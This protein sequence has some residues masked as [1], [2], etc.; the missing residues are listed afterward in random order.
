LPFRTPK[1]R[2]AVAPIQNS[3]D[4]TSFVLFRGIDPAGNTT[5]SA[6]RMSALLETLKEKQRNAYCNRNSYRNHHVHPAA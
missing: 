5:R 6:A 1:S 2:P 4:L 3:Y